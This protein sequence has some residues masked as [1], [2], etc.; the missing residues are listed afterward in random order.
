VLPSISNNCP[1]KILVSDFFLFPAYCVKQASADASAAFPV[2]H[3]ACHRNCEQQWAQWASLLYSRFC[4]PWLLGL[5][6]VALGDMK[7]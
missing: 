5:G 4:F 2:S 3:G 1:K 6:A 7:E